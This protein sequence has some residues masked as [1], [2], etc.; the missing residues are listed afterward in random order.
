[1][2]FGINTIIMRIYLHS[3]DAIFILLAGKTLEM[4]LWLLWGVFGK[5]RH[6]AAPTIA[7]WLGFA[8][9]PQRK[10]RHTQSGARLRQTADDRENERVTQVAIFL[11]LVRLWSLVFFGVKIDGK[12]LPVVDDSSAWGCGQSW[13]ESNGDLDFYWHQ[14]QEV[15]EMWTLIWLW[16]STSALE[17]TEDHHAPVKCKM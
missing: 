6:Y 9:L 3:T 4:Q 13:R 14:W 15:D 7:W 17:E 5:A 8:V 10:F 2:R 11:T 1:M 16:L 12:T